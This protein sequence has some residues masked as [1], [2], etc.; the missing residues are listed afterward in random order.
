MGYHMDGL[1]GGRIST[2]TVCASF[3]EGSEVEAEYCTRGKG[4]KWYPAKILNVHHNDKITYDI[5]WT[6]EEHSYNEN[7]LAHR[8]RWPEKCRDLAKWEP[9]EFGPNGDGILY[10]DARFLKALSASSIRYA[11]FRDVHNLKPLPSGNK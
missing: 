7:W 2:W 8:I 5:K 11:E 9:L 10:Y 3:K 4:K 6:S 1:R